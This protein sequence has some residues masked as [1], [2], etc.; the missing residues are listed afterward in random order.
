MNSNINIR[1]LSVKSLLKLFDYLICPILMYESEVW[2][3]F[4][5]QN[6]DKWDANQIEKVHIQ[7]IKR[8]LGLNRSTSTTLIRGDI[9][10]HSLKSRI[11][12][13]N[14]KYLKQIK[15]KDNDSLVKQAYNY[16]HSQITKR[17]T[18]ENTIKQ[19]GNEL[20]LTTNILYNLP[21]KILKI[22]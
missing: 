2:E 3:P 10:R 16:E 4:L 15:N 18:I 5:N 14:I 11:V 19:L 21:P 7:F 8:I 1:Y 12:L 6:D 13:R 22:R 9:G 17:I 20:N